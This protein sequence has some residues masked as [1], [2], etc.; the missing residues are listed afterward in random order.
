MLDVLK[1]IDIWIRRLLTLFCALLLAMMVIFTV[2]TVFM[3]YVFENPPPWGDQMAVFS[4]IWLV[5]IALALTTREKE[6]IALDM[7]YTYLSPKWSFT[8]QETWN[9]IICVLGAVIMVY[10]YDTAI[11]NFGK[12]WE[13]NY[14][15]KKYPMMILPT[16]GALIMVGAFVAFLEDVAAYRKG[17]FHAHEYV[18]GTDFVHDDEPA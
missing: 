11:N 9:L 14:L 15:P 6:H 18:D 8:V 1:A 16:T 3:R 13:L 4:C 17:E 7:L 12:Y 10:G 5:F 2:Y